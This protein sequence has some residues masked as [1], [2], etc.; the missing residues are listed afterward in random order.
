MTG[1]IP[2]SSESAIIDANDTAI[3]I[4]PQ[5]MAQSQGPQ[6]RNYVA[7]IPVPISDD[8]EESEEYEEDEYYYDEDE[9]YYYEEEEEPPPKRRRPSKKKNRRRPPNRRGPYY[10]E[11]EKEEKVP[12]LVPLMMVPETE[13]GVDKKFSFA[14][15]QLTPPQNQNRPNGGRI[16]QTGPPN[17]VRPNNIRPNNRPFRNNRKMFV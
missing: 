4:L 15:D 3:E 12:F 16:P 5:P 9:E 8:E 7:Y 1:I 11:E 17:N 14:G 13:I 10:E 2:P 6:P